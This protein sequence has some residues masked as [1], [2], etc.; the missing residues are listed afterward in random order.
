LYLTV[1]FL[2]CLLRPMAGAQAPI[3]VK[4]PA[5]SQADLWTGINVKGTVHLLVR[6]RSGNDTAKLW[7]VT[8]GIGSVTQLGNVTGRQDVAIPIAW[9]RGVVSARLRAEA[10]E[11]TVIYVSDEAAVDYSKTFKW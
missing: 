9:W 7:W 8:W 5:G 6:T 10:S 2:V 3:E 4:V 11:D 1:A